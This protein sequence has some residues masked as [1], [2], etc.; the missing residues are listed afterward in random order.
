MSREINAKKI[1]TMA[2]LGSNDNSPININSGGNTPHAERV[3]AII[4]LQNSDS[5][6]IR[7][8]RR[9]I[10]LA[11][12][13]STNMKSRFRRSYLKLAANI[14]NSQASRSVTQFYTESI[15]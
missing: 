2:Q 8:A 14:M 13:V 1:K 11:R 7:E 10:V 15:Y 5:C 6:R 9:R 4:Y 12:H 3:H